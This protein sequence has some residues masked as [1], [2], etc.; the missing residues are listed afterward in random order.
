[1]IARRNLGKT[2]LTVTELGFG[3]APAWTNSGLTH[4]LP[5]TTFAIL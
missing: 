5:G 2:G 1:M 3:A 4:S